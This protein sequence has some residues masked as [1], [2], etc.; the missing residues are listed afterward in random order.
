[1]IVFKRCICAGKH[2][3]FSGN[4]VILM[5]KRKLTKSKN[6]NIIQEYGIRKKGKLI[7]I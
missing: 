4:T 7:E 3:V 6:N 5:A 2:S 1:M